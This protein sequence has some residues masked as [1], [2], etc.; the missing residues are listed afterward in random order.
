LG[1]R[2]WWRR[3][4]LHVHYKLL[5]NKGLI[6]FKIRFCYILCYVIDFRR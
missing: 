2:I 5:I 6:R 1:F 3:R 4:E